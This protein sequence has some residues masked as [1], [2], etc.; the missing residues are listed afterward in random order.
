VSYWTFHKKGL[1]MDGRNAYGNRPPRSV[2]S[3]ASSILRKLDG[4]H[5]D[6]KV[7]GHEQKMVRLWIDSGA[8]YPGTYAS[9]GCGMYPVQF[10]EDII[11]RRCGK[12]HSGSPPKTPD[13]K[14]GKYYQFGTGP[15]Q[16]LSTNV[17]DITS[18]RRMAYYK[19]GEAGPHQSL[20]NL[21][22]PDMSLLVRAPLAKEAGGLGL[23][24][25]AV[26]KEKDDPDYK[27]LVAAIA[28]ASGRLEEGKRFD[29]A[30]FVPAKHYIRE[31]KRFSILPPDLS[32]EAKIDIYRSEERRVGKEC[33][34][35]WSPYH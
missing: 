24:R 28:E 23:C 18:I 11:E 35:R 22:R 16:T 29:M 21:T 20:C 2:G 6:V 15:A 25:K 26:F 1:F 5:N 17:H 3:G 7:S 14:K 27:Q 19:M 8:T 10:P 34:S 30:G 31:M 33:R 9:L 13:A 32:L 4:S 12:C